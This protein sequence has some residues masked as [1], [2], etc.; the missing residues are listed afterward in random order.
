MMPFSPLR[1]WGLG[2]LGWAIV[3]GG[4][5]CLWEWADGAHLA[6]VERREV[7]DPAS[8]QVVREEQRVIATADNH[9]GWPYLL[10]GLALLTV[11]FGG[12][13][14]VSLFLGRSGSGEPLS[15]RPGQ[16]Q[17][18]DRP[19]GSRLCMETLGNQAGP[20]LLFTHGW[21]L[22][23][24]AWYYV[25]RELAGR[26]RI[27][28]WD[29]PGLGQSRRPANYD[30]RLEKMADDLA[31]VV[32]RVGLGPTIL[33]GHSIG[34]MITQTFCRRHAEEL[35]KRVVGIVLLHTT[36][37]NP[38]RTAFLASVWTAIEKPVIVP[39]NYVTAWLAP[40]AW[41]SNLQGYL[42]GSLHIMTR[43]TSFAG[44]QTWGQIDYGAWLAAKAWPGVVARGNLAMLD[45]DE[46][47]TLPDIDIPALVIAGRGDILTKPSASATL[48]ASLP[49]G[50]AAAV[51]GGHLG[52]WERH[53]DVNALIDEFAAKFTTPAGSSRP[54]VGVNNAAPA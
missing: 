40:L 48:E 26:Y 9:G 24:T 27:V 35:G 32:E 46:Q 1:T 49:Q 11:S 29:L 43:L 39:L 21:S 5:Y 50:I 51:Q 44:N 15:D 23:S 37:I 8:G 52:F 20:T 14:P 31:A 12:S 53:S 4:I 25:K 2:L 45:F 7:R 41:L 18:I 38:L 16:R 33:V 28:V 42:N 34:G 22:D 19:D 30:F 6:I 17:W 3:A 47:S 13:W 54:E 10:G 36:F